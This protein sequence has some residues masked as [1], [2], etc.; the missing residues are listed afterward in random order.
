MDDLTAFAV[1]LAAAVIAGL[2]MNRV[3]MPA[4]A[5]FIVVG[6]V[7]GPTGFG[8]IAHSGAIQTLAD[9]GVLMLLFILGMEL[10]LASFR[11]LLPL[12]LG[13]VLAEIAVFT[14]FTT[15]LAQL[16][17]GE[18]SSAVVIGFMLAISSTAL[19]IKMMEDADEAK[20]RA[21]KLTIAI[22]VAQ[23]LAVVPLL[24]LTGAM[25]PG[26]GPEALSWAAVK[27]GVA[28]A[29]LA[30]FIVLLARIKSFRFPAS[31]FLLHD[32]DGGT[33]AVLAVCFAAAALSGV[34]G[35]SPALGA[36][37]AGLAVGH[38][39]LRRTAIALAQ[40]VQ[41]ILIF[42]FFLSIGLLI[43]LHYVLTHLWLIVIVL[44]VVT[45][46]KTALNLMLLHVAG[47]PGEVAFPAALFLSPVGEFS[48][49]LASAGAAAGALT[50][51]GHKLAI[52]VIALSLLVSPLWFVGARRAHALALRGITEAD[53]LFE[54]AYARELFFLR[55]WGRR[56]ANVGAQAAA[57][58]A[59]AGTSVVAANTAPKRAPPAVDPDDAYHEPFG[60]VAGPGILPAQPRDPP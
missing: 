43:D 10:R 59:A 20:T 6:V 9:L 53:A 32:V 26:A 1:V 30:G 54:E 27:L 4:V 42:I 50:P 25:A 55:H 8:L 21:G 12:A 5:G 33:L 44:A 17:H 13:I 36:F 37:L 45:V 11:R 16:A 35:L 47:Q 15:A 46:G 19:A 31:Q 7:L 39:T 34:L 22:L 49:V 57:A 60:D 2:L 14:G 48:F 41:S 51:E 40:P 52:A 58:A 18:T 29:L 28:V 38:S 56:A 3:R 24:L 23:D